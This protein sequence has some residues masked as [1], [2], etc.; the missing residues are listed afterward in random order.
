MYIRNMSFMDK[1]KG[2]FGFQSSDGTRTI[3]RRALNAVKDFFRFN[4]ANPTTK[5]F[6]N[7]FTNNPLV[8]MV[9]AKIAS[10]SSR[11]PRIVVDSNG[12]VIDTPV[13]LDILNSTKKNHNELNEEIG[14]SL[15]LT[16]NAYVLYISGSDLGIDDRVKFLKTGDVEPKVSNNGIQIG[17]TYYNEL[18]TLETFDLDEVLHLKTSN[19]VTND[20][21]NHMLGLSPLCAGWIVVQSSDEKFN[22]EASIF[23]NRGI[24]G[25]V[26]TK[27]DIPMKPAERERMQDSLDDRAGGSD[28]FNKLL[29]SETELQYIQTGMSPTDLKLLD[30]ILSSLRIICGLYGLP[31]VLL[32]DNDNSSYNNFS[33]AVEIAYT[34]VYLPL[35]EKIDEKLSMFISEKQGVEEFI[36]VDVNQVDQIK[37]STHPVAQAL[38]NFDGKVAS[39]IASA[40]TKDEAR[41]TLTLDS[42]GGGDEFLQDNSNGQTNQD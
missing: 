1:V 42:I 40:M 23:K 10:T 36:K 26:T 7:S 13:I 6:L 34:D 25:F 33:T 14:Q 22:A 32:N 16:G 20:R 3:G 28:K 35:A 24:A 8:F 27:G 2:A 31:S 17:W 19:I 21:D 39:M 4:T 11:L 37:T 12:D 9:V 41:E 38:S 29:L 30:G 5:K 15:L 18:G